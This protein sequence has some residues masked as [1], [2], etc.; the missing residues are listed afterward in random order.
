MSTNFYFSDLI[1]FLPARL[2][3][4]RSAEENSNTSKARANET[5]AFRTMLKVQAIYL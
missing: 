5:K 1:S 2:S 3:L 4:T